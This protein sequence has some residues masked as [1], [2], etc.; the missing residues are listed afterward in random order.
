ME[1]IDTWVRSDRKDTEQEKGSVLLTDADVPSS[2]DASS[3]S[4]RMVIT[5]FT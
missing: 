4:S 3:S 1:E 5:T 2:S